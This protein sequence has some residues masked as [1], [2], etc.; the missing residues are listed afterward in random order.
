MAPGDIVRHA[1]YPQ[2][3][4]GYVI[5]VKKASSEIFFRAGRQTKDRRERAAR[6]QPGE[7]SRGGVLRTVRE[8]VAEIVVTGA[9][10]RLRRRARSSG[11]EESRL[12]R[13][14]SWRR[15]GRIPV[16]RRDRAHARRAVRASPGGHA[17]RTLRPRA[18]PQAEARPGGRILAPAVPDCRVH[19]TESRRMV[20]GAGIRGVAE[21][22]RRALQGCCAI[23]TCRDE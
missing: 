13:A 16:R 17:I 4:R 18:R 3:G 9:P 20:T 5:R 10:Q 14:E 2:W 12:S 22:T 23:S 1:D 21:L 7:R 15:G 19:G 6:T 11:M 8:R